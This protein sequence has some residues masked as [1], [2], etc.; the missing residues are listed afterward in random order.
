[1]GKTQIFQFLATGHQRQNLSS[2]KQSAV[3]KGRNE[4]QARLSLY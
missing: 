2:L 3:Q 1:M 4:R